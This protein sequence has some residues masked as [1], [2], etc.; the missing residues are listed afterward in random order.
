MKPRVLF[1][2]VLAMVVGVHVAAAANKVAI[3]GFYEADAS[4]DAV[5]LGRKLI[6]LFFVELATDKDVELVERQAVQKVLDELELGID[7]LSDRT[8]AARVGKMLGAN[9]LVLG[10]HF[11]SGSHTNM[12]ALKVVQSE[13]SVIDEFVILR[14]TDSELEAAAK[15]LASIVRRSASC[16]ATD[17]AVVLGVGRFIQT[18]LGKYNADVKGQVLAYFMQRYA[19]KPGVTLVERSDMDSLL[20]EKALVRQGFISGAATNGISGVASVLLSGSYQTVRTDKTL[21]EMTIK[22]SAQGKWPYKRV[23]RGETVADVFEKAGEDLDSYIRTLSSGVTSGDRKAEINAQWDRIYAITT[24]AGKS[25]R[26]YKRGIDT[27]GPC[28]KKG[29]FDSKFFLCPRFSGTPDQERAFIGAFEAIALLSEEKSEVWVV[30]AEAYKRFAASSDGDQRS[31]SIARLQ[32]IARSGKDP[33]ARYFAG[34]T[35]WMEEKISL[36]EDARSKYRNFDARW[37]MAMA[38]MGIRGYLSKR[39]GLAT[40]QEYYDRLQKITIE[41]CRRIAASQKVEEKDAQRLLFI[42]DRFAWGPSYSSTRA[43]NRPYR[44]ALRNNVM[45]AV[46]ET[47]PYFLF[48]S[49]MFGSGYDN[50]VMLKQKELTS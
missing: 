27:I 36:P 23:I 43:D 16:G 42:A 50:A 31:K 13:S 46:P 38:R 7:G 4:N 2:L 19:S 25:G 6:D 21:L 39:Y 49:R 29:E 30:V 45:R 28:N 41:L 11:I 47:A 34:V 1:F 12:V 17:E 8:T 33:E 40:P 3:C 20:Q 48:N 26:A 18:G 9:K 15:R 37:D 14:L 44:L 22:V 5:E 24:A 35:L 32:G 10:T